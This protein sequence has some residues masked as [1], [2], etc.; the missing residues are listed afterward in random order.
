MTGFGVD[1][2]AL[3]PPFVIGKLV[4]RYGL[5]LI[6]QPAWLALQV[7][8]RFLA[9]VFGFSAGIFGHS[10]DRY[11]APSANPTSW[12]FRPGIIGDDGAAYGMDADETL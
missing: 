1:Y 8:V 2:D 7:V 6:V 9:S 5:S 12:S 3:R 4:W 10:G 11:D